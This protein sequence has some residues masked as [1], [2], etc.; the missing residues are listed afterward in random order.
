MAPSLL[1]LLLAL[2][3]THFHAHARSLA[4]EGTR[5]EGIPRDYPGAGGSTVHR[6]HTLRDESP[7]GFSS[8]GGAMIHRRHTRA[9]AHSEA[10]HSQERGSG[11]MALPRGRQLWVLRSGERH[12]ALGPAGGVDASA[13][14]TAPATATAAAPG[15]VEGDT[16]GKISDK[17]KGPKVR[18]HQVTVKTLGGLSPLSWVVT[19]GDGVS[20]ATVYEEKCFQMAALS[21]CGARI[22]LAEDQRAWFVVYLTSTSANVK[23]IADI[24]YDPIQNTHKACY[25]A[26]TVGNYSLEA[27]V[28]FT[29]AYNLTHVIDPV[30]ELGFANYTTVLK[31]TVVVS[32]APDFDLVNHRNGLPVCTSSQLSASRNMGY[33]VEDTWYPT[34][35]RMRRL[36]QSEMLRCLDGKRV[37][38]IGDSE[39][40]I[41]YGILQAFLYYKSRAEFLSEVQNRPFFYG[42]LI[43]HVL[44]ANGVPQ[45]T[46]PEGPPLNKTTGKA[47][48]V[49]YEFLKGV[50]TTF[51]GSIY[52]GFSEQQMTANLSDYTGGANGQTP[53]GTVR[54]NLTLSSLFTV[55]KELFSPWKLDGNLTGDVNVS[56]GGFPA[57]V[58]FV[59]NQLHDV[60]NYNTSEEY[61]ISLISHF[62]PLIFPLLK[63]PE[64][65][66][67]QGGLSSIEARKIG[68]LSASANPRIVDFEN[69]SLQALV[70]DGYPSFLRMQPLTAP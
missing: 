16:G 7:W 20:K 30:N 60:R 2:L 9:I 24:T 26:P 5:G 63:S 45:I 36:E 53:G 27:K 40:R 29:N 42:D 56:D 17:P 43:L 69:L 32:G 59:A 66:Y 62:M 37:L 23:L 6:R 48:K 57:D 22:D 39:T 34:T 19:V 67:M 14:A 4:L 10:L 33:W 8:A 49:E 12:R 51:F 52:E 68:D 3:C 25:T 54:F 21:H 47:R 41:V 13:P 28:V 58:V 55:G 65:L 44:S 35:C 38:M 46:T 31:S 70:D 15:P 1:P 61:I 64:S 11:K 50:N 18:W